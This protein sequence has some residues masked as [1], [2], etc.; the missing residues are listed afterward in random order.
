MS[1]RVGLSGGIG[2]GKSTVAALF[3]EQGI[4]VIDSDAISHQLTQAGGAA[5]ASIRAAFG[6]EYINADSSL[7]RIRMRQQIFS[8]HSDAKQKLEAILHPLIR[9]QMLAQAQASGSSSYLLLVVPLLFEASNY[10]ELAQRTLVVDC[11]E[12]TQ[13]ERAMQRSILSEQEVRAIMAQQISRA[14]RLRLADDVIHN[15]GSMDELR[16]QVMQLHQEYLN[17]SSKITFRP[18]RSD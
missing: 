4:T 16:H 12:K 13:V 5:I 18:S 3:Q 11:A 7:N 1:Y 9:A 15:D 14:E 2:S 6:G 8:D 10:R 17:H